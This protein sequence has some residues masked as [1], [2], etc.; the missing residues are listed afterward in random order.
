MERNKKGNKVIFKEPNQVEEDPILYRIK[1]ISYISRDF[2]HAIRNNL[3]I[4]NNAA[5]VI[6]MRMKTEDPKTIKCI[7][8]MLLILSRTGSRFSGSTSCKI[9]IYSSFNCHRSPETRGN[10][11]QFFIILI[12]FASNSDSISFKA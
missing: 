1:G 11:G 8:V 3:S 12:F 9:D 10:L 7:D 5:E 4:M 2:G 6:R